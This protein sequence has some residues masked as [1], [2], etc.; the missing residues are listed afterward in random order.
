MCQRPRGAVARGVTVLT[1][2]TSGNGAM[3]TGSELSR[4]RRR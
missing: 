2:E 3:P 4:W 1:T